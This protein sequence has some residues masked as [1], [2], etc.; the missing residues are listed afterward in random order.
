MTSEYRIVFFD[1]RELV[2]ALI[3]HAR[4]QGTRLPPGQAHR[5]SID[6]TSFDV[7]LYFRRRGEE[8]VQ[9]DFHSASLA[10]ALIR[11]CKKKG[12]PLP[13]KSNKELR[14]VDDRLAFVVEIARPSTDTL[15]PLEYV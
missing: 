7:R 15:I 4:T 9:V 10:Q 14:M 5:M 11:H 2:G 3:E 8:P 1:E 6:R 13:V 12:I